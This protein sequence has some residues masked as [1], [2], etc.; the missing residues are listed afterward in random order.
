MNS[1]SGNFVK[2]YMN[3]VCNLGDTFAIRHNV[4]GATVNTP[5][6]CTLE[7]I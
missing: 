3:I 4:V 2:K 5:A 6:S 1:A 7:Y